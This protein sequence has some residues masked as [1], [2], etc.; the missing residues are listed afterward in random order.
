MD[1]CQWKTII[2]Y[3]VF[4]GQIKRGRMPFIQWFITPSPS[5]FLWNTN[6]CGLGYC[7]L[8]NSQYEKYSPK[9]HELGGDSLDLLPLYA[10][11]MCPLSGLITGMMQ[12][13]V[14]TCVSAIGT[15][16]CCSKVSQESDRATTVIIK[17]THG[18]NYTTWLQVREGEWKRKAERQI[19]EAKQMAWS[20]RG[21][22]VGWSGERARK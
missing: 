17:H 8:K 19:V 16:T 18:Y 7:C 10:W 13:F 6:P 3:C 14:W 21:V 2:K 20:S 15:S 12:V 9:W 4:P 1:D 22:D 5:T 11:N